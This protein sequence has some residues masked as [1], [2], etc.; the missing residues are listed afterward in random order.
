MTATKEKATAS[1]MAQSKTLQAN[2]KLCSGFGQYHTNEADPAKPN[3]RLTPYAAIGLDEIWRMAENPQEVDKAQ[4]QWT[5]VS[6]LPS[7]SSAQQEAHGEYLALWCDFDKSPRPIPEIA[8]FWAKVSGARAVHYSSRSAKHDCQK[9]RLFVPLPYPL[10]AEEWALAAECLNDLFEQAGFIPDRVSERLVQL[11]YLPNRGESYEWHK[12]DG[13]LLDPMTFFAEAIQAKR[14]S[15]EQELAEAEKR[16]KVAEINRAN[17]KASESTSAVDAFN[18]LHTVEDVL[19]KAGYSRKGA[20]F[21]HPQ[22]ESGGYSVSIK[23]GRAY[24]HSPND[25]LYTANESN[26]AHDAFSAWAVLFFGN[27][28]SEAAKTVYAQIKGAS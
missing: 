5:L 10:S 4:A 24:S 2:I 6:T 21:R 12:H 8:A 14:Q 7:R 19:L 15:I 23:N 22:S 1:T 27:D 26:G 25:P 17:F 9:S 11:C 18:A 13:E 16:R 3:K 20:R 28:P